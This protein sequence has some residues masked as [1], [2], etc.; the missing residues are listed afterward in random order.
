M[1]SYN[2]VE[3]KNNAKNKE[4]NMVKNYSDKYMEIINNNLIMDNDFE[5]LNEISEYESFNIGIDY[6]DCNKNLFNNFYKKINKEKEE[7]KEIIDKKKNDMVNFIK[8]LQTIR[9]PGEANEEN[10]YRILSFPWCISGHILSSLKF[11]NLKV[12]E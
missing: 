7:I 3:L 2:I 12:N 11:L 5:E 1:I 10:Q 8:N 9:I 4:E 6:Y